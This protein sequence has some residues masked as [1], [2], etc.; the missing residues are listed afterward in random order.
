MYCFH[1]LFS[2]SASIQ[3]N[4][5]NS[6]K[7]MVKLI[8]NEYDMNS[9]DIFEVRNEFIYQITNKVTDISKY[10]LNILTSNYIGNCNIITKRRRIN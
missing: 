3:H 6:L 4:N 5:F 2:N 9:I 10:N 8:K 1:R 7:N